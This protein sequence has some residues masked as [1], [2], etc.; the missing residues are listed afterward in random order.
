MQALLGNGP[1]DRRTQQPLCG[2]IDFD[3]AGT[4][5][6]DWVMSSMA[7]DDMAQSYGLGLVKDNV[8]PSIYVVCIGNL[9]SAIDASELPFAPSAAGVGISGFTWQMSS[10]PFL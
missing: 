3:V 5:Q 10:S 6:G 1:G 4:A 8:D 2:K 9:G 7:D